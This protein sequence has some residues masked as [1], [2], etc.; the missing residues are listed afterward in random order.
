MPV[1]IVLWWRYLRY[2][3]VMRQRLGDQISAVSRMGKIPYAVFSFVL[4]AAVF[5]L[6]VLALTHPQLRT[7]KNKP[8]Y[9]NIDLV[10]LLDV[11]PSMYAQDILPSRIERAREVLGKFVVRK[12]DVDRVALVTFSETSVILSYLTTDPQNIL[13]YLDFIR[14]ERQSLYGTNIGAGLQSGLVVLA[15]DAEFQKRNRDHK[16]FL[17]LLSDGED[18][19]EELEKSLDAVKKAEIRIHTVGIG[20][21]GGA[22]MP[23]PDERGRITYLTD[24]RGVRIIS[25]FDEA[26]LRQIAQA[27][28]GR[29]FRSFT[30]EDI[31]E[32]LEKIL[33]LERDVLGYHNVLEHVELY[34]ELLLTGLV[35]FLVAILVA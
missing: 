14:A 9:R 7:F 6:L 2:K 27:T 8:I 29:F 10:F 33:T 25:R 18:H 35:L 23:I 5:V 24:E 15:K 21:K 31:E 26:T 22:P 19:G 34:P 17:I 28:R 16:Q 3:Q 30:G 12:L 11:S 4:T 32:S 20:S 1:L 13:F